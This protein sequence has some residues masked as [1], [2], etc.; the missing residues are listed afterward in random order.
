MIWIRSV[1]KPQNIVMKKVCWWHMGSPNIFIIII[2]KPMLRKLSTREV[3]WLNCFF[4]QHDLSSIL[5]LNYR[6][7]LLMGRWDEI[8]DSWVWLQ[9]KMDV[10]FIAIFRWLISSI[11]YVML[12]RFTKKNVTTN[13]WG[14]L[15]SHLIK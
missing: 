5:V 14:N 15:T 11:G 7:S 9:S 8:W 2:C 13:H 3:I 1:L 10:I 4:L 6:Y 12:A